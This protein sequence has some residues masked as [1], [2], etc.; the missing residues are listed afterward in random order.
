MHLA[1]THPLHSPMSVHK[2]PGPFMV[3]PTPGVTG[4]IFSCPNWCVRAPLHRLHLPFLMASV[5]R[6]HVLICSPYIMFGEM[7]IEIV[8]P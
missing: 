2:N 1:K 5:G 6:F 4:F 7:S 3:S 8:H